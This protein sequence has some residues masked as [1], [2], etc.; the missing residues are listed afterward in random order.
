[1][2][3]DEVVKGSK[4]VKAPPVETKAGSD[5]TGEA[6]G[7]IIG[8]LKDVDRRTRISIRFLQGI[9]AFMILLAVGFIIVNDDILTR[10]G[11]GFLIMSFFV[12]IYMQQLRYKA[13]NETYLNTPMVE[14]LQRAKK[15]MRVFTVRSWLAIP[16][17]LLID[18]GLCLLIY[19]VSD[20][21]DFPVGYVILILQ[22]PIVMAAAA[23]FL[24]EYLIWKRE[25]KP[26]VTRID[27]ILDDIEASTQLR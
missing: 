17:W 18:V 4:R 20:R 11:V 5:G 2:K 27:R 22:V 1:M 19:A 21:F 26:V 3:Y 9:F 24:V 7:T 16:A 15:R 13:Y 25:H 10:S 6:S 23:D 8:A 14:Y 12:V